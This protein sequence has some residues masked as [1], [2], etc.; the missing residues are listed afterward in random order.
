MLVFL[1]ILVGALAHATWNLVVKR[2][3]V[4]GP[5]FVWLTAVGA[6]L[7]LIPIGI[8]VA[9]L[10]PP[11]WPDLALA[12]FVSAI[13]HVGYFLALQAGYRAGDVG[14]VYP[15]AR[16]TGPLL[17]VVFAIVLFGERPGPLGL[18]GAGAVIAGVVIIGLGGGRANWR[19]AR[20]GVIWGLTIG[21]VIA[22]YT[23]WDAHAVTALALSPILLNA[24]TSSLEAVL[25][26]PIAV[27]RWATA[28]AV[29][30]DH[31]KDVL[32]VSTLSP[33]SYI[34][35]LFAMQLAPVS[36]VAPAREISVVFVA[37]AGWL[38]F[39]EPHPVPRLTG[40]VVV[41]AG[42]ALLAASR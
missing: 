9:V 27:R 5:T 23:L 31:W 21:V 37:I 34:L 30:R 12:A 40:A 32:V 10:E 28:K 19:A 3:A 41:V 13:L 1:L 16:G 14:V 33:L 22:A 15:L 24:G 29:L 18:L 17:S 4:S 38:L 11:S 2:S 39:R 26:T 8:V 20:A 42:V 36:I 35:I 25:M 6:A 7:I